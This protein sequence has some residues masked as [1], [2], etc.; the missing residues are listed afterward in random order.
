LQVR[1]LSPL[2]SDNEKTVSNCPALVNGTKEDEVADSKRGGRSDDD[3]FEN[4]ELDEFDDDDELDDDDVLDDSVDDNADEDD[5]ADDLD[6]D[7]DDE[8]EDEDE[9]A[10]AAARS[11]TAAKSAKAGSATKTRQ[12]ARPKKKAKRKSDVGPGLI[13][14]FVRFVREVVA[15]LQKVIW[16]TRNE[17][18]TYTSVVVV[19]VTIMMTLV[20]L[21]D[22][23]FART[24]FAVFGG[25]TTSTGG[26]TGQ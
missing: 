5:E 25:T 6:D 18:V 17:L 1:A 14:R 12:V 22:L 16:P 10:P 4:A 26:T 15:E 7:E 20:A 8:E 11:G 21:L 3:E 9:D 19:F 24:M 13:G 23:G 2:P